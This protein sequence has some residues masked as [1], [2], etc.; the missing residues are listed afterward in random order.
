M[1]YDYETEAGCDAFERSS[2]RPIE[3]QTWGRFDIRY[4]Y[5]G[6]LDEFHET[7]L[8]M[9]VEQRFAH[10]TEDEYW[11]HEDEVEAYESELK[12]QF[13]EEQASEWSRVDI[14]EVMSNY[15]CIDDWRT[16]PGPT[17]ARYM[18]PHHGDVSSKA[19]RIM[20][21]KN[22]NNNQVKFKC[23]TC[24]ANHKWALKSRALA[25]KNGESRSEV[26]RKYPIEKGFTYWH[27]LSTEWRF[28][29]SNY[30]GGVLLCGMK[31]VGHYSILK[32]FKVGEIMSVATLCQSFSKKTVYKKLRKEIEAG[33]I[34][35]HKPGFYRR[36]K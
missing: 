35:K 16:L 8:E 33:T 13:L 28:Q 4:N 7:E 23:P 2:P 14:G 11:E 27:I 36:I 30:L 10:L 24:Q 5:G 15:H 19:N 3:E 21:Y 18:C 32:L 9:L 17:K 29:H 31:T 22:P 20:L 6:E 25:Y 26:C 34:V 12:A 1:E